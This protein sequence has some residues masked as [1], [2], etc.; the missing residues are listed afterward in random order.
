MGQQVDI[1][2]H[3]FVKVEV[4]HEAGVRWNGKVLAKGQ[5]FVAK[6]YEI[7]P[8][9]RAG[10]VKLVAVLPDY[11]PAAAREPEDLAVATEPPVEDA[12]GD[13]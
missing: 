13:P 1:T 10:Q 7:E 9:V 2:P 8:A 6:Q 3:T 11:D 4:I 12:P 5:T